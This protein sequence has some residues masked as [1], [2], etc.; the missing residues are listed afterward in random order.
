MAEGCKYGGQP[1]LLTE[2]GGIAKKGEAVGGNW[3]YND[4][5]ADD[6]EFYARY[7]NLVDGIYAVGDFQGFCY[8]QLTDV[9][10]EVNGLLDADHKP[11]FDLITLRK[12]TEHK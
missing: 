4:G 3:G 7:Q 9:Q 5:A 1:V 12:L 8:T 10:Q 11:K 2:F 6:E